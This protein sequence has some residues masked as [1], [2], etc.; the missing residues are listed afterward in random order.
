MEN[1]SLPSKNQNSDD[2]IAESLRCNEY[3]FTVEGKLA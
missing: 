3:E 1:D 2:A